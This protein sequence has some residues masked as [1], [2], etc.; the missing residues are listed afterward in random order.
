MEE[1]L[2][3][4]IRGNVLLATRYFQHRVKNFIT[5]VVMGK[6]NPMNVKYYTYKVEFQDRGAG[7]VHG[8]LWLRLNKIENLTRKDGKLIKRTEDEPTLASTM[9]PERDPQR[10]PETYRDP[11]DFSHLM[12]AFKRI[13]NNECNA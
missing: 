12:S 13:R 10:D 11:K 9:M 6:N 8:T 1:S 2:H 7:H 3:E 5:K 4:L